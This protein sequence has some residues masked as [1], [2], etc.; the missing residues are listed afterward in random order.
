[1][2]ANLPEDLPLRFEHQKSSGGWGTPS[3]IG[4]LLLI[5]TAI[6]AGLYSFWSMLALNLPMGCA[7][8]TIGVIRLRNHPLRKWVER[9]DV[10]DGWVRLCRQDRPMQTDLLFDAPYSEF[11]FVHLED[12]SDADAESEACS[13]SLVHVGGRRFPLL[14]YFTEDGTLDHEAKLTIKKLSNEI[15]I[16]VRRTDPLR[17]SN[18]HYTG[19][20]L[21]IGPDRCPKCGH[22]VTEV[23]T[24]FC[25]NCWRELP[26]SLQKE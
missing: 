19:G 12:R 25:P 8:T 2:I 17:R 26:P 24:I 11:L 7:L 3:V 16:P 15:G 23:G 1:M 13:V 5:A 21:S 18:S 20:I 4:G 9:V 14:T 6:Y 22:L 10:G